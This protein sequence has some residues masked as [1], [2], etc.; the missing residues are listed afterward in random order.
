MNAMISKSMPIVALAAVVL[1]GGCERPPVDAVQRG[2]RGTAMVEMYNPRTVSAQIASNKLPEM[3]PALPADGPLASTVYKNVQV[4]G[5]LSV[6]EFTRTMLAITSWVAPVQGCAYCHNAGDDFS[7]DA[8]YTKSVARKMLAMTAN[9]NGKWSSHVVATGV[10]CYT[11]HR[12]QNIPANVWFKQPESPQAMRLVGNPAGQNK[13]GTNVGL[14]SLPNDVFTPFLSEANEIRVIGTKPLPYGNRTSTKQA[15]WTYGLMAH[16]S[17]SLGVNCTYC[18]NSRSFGSWETS[19]PQRTTA[20]YGIRMVRELNNGYMEPLTATFPAGRKGVLG[21]VAKVNC[22]TCH[23]GAFKPMYGAPML[24]DYPELTK[25]K[26][27]A[28]Q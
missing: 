22:T 20:W 26:T 25:I 19:T 17:T 9:I 21:D 27:A 6:N 2:F 24:K 28:A 23:Q 1:L 3:V 12:G 5:D 15:E 16:M 7:V 18:H 13:P 14:A 11:C 4:L 8:L 10:T